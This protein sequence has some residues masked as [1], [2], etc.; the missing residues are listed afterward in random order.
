MDTLL[1]VGS[2]HANRQM[3]DVIRTS[4][5]IL[6]AGLIGTAL[7]AMTVGE[8]RAAGFSFLG[9]SLTIYFRETRFSN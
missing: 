6:A 2:F 5:A 3:V 7:I 1:S 8:L 9:A 4:L